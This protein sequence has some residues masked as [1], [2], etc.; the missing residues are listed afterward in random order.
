MFNVV[1]I[2]TSSLLHDFESCIEITRLNYWRNY[3][4]VDPAILFEIQFRK[5]LLEI[6]LRQV[7]RMM[8]YRS[9]SISGI[10]NHYGCWEFAVFEYGAIF[11][12]DGMFC[13]IL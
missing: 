2:R 8:K 1:Y 6:Q 9:G 12:G 5:V 11:S 13:E 7:F 4:K 10:D 3:L